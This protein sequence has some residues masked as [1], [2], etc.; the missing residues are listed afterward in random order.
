MTRWRTVVLAGGLGTRMQ[1]RTPKPLHPVCGQPLIRHVISAARKALSVDPVLVI[2]PEAEGLRNV[3]ED[4][5]DFVVQDRPLGTG[6]ALL[7]ARHLLEG[8]A[9]QILVLY[10][11]TPLLRSET[12]LALMTRHT[13]SGADVTFLTAAG[14]LQDGLARVVRDPAGMAAAIVEAADAT[15]Q[16]RRLP[17]TNAGVYCF[18]GEDLWPRLARL[19]PAPSGELY[20]TS[21]ISLT[22][23]DGGRVETVQAG[24]NTEA[25]GVN[26]RL[27]LAMAEALLRERIRRSWMLAG[28]TIQD[29]ATTYIDSAV[30]LGRDT[31]LLPN[32]HLRGRT[33]I[34]EGCRL[35][36]NAIIADSLLGEGCTVVAAVLEGAT[37]EA[38]VDVGPFSHLRPGSY[39][40]RGVHLGNFVEV[41]ESRLGARSQVG[42]FSYIGDST[43]GAG[44]NIG[45]G[46]VTCNYD[47]ESKLRTTIGDGAFIGSATMLVAPV[48]V[49][50]GAATGAGSVV[51]ADVAPGDLVVGVPAR[52][53]NHKKASKGGDGE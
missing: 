37:L 7:C 28:V 27:E 1:S 9:D 14:S 46:T 53:Q 32:T 31:V 16:E 41:K 18:R 52:P 35:G 33:R 48:T 15:E 45:A 19:T 44:V 34:G 30:E 3:L 43:L 22:R 50:R 29:P 17:E 38:G 11:D 25:L 24:D 23:H 6:H 5:A 51:T 20:L 39:A 13:E 49:G 40:E 4:A 42:H 2:G 36:P 47:G 8:K 12:L 26:T 21:L 10:A